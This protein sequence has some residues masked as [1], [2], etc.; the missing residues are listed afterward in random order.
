[1]TRGTITTGGAITVEVN[2]AAVNGLSVTVADGAVAGE[3]DSDTP[4]D[5]HATTAVAVG[6]RIE[7]I[8]ASAFNASADIFV[9]LEIEAT[10]AAGNGTFVAGVQT[11]PTATT[12]DVRGT[13]APT[14]TP[15][16]STHF[17]L[18]VATADPTYKGVA[19]YDG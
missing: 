2:T 10:E 18:L 8:P 5:G 1:M 12:G 7:I 11:T 14:T 13:Y 4:T 3:V 17:S 19:Q 15:D 16:G 9:I 6:D